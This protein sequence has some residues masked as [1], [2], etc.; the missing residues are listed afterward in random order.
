M[1]REIKFRVWDKT[2]WLYQDE[3][4]ITDGECN[5][6]VMGGW[7]S[8]NDLLIQQYTGLKD[9]NGVEIFEGDIIINHISYDKSLGGQYETPVGVVKWISQKDKMDYSGWC[10]Y[11]A[12]LPWG[13]EKHTEVIGNIYENPELL[14]A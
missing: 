13:E 12:D 1:N 5:E 14:K 2:R 6:L 9:K 10:A 4:I 7:K 3:F 8:R 11:P